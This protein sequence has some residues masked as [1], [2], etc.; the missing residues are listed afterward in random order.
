MGI[1]ERRISS[2]VRISFKK[3]YC[4]MGALEKTIR[5]EN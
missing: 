1:A 4:K 3:T 5:E 2:F